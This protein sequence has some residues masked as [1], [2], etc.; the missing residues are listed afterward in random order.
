MFRLLGKR[1]KPFSLA[2]Q[3]N[4][5]A[6]KVDKKKTKKLWYYQEVFDTLFKVY[7]TNDLKK[8]KGNN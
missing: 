4:Y 1:N 2:W 7:N 3:A 5:A 6:T 8:I